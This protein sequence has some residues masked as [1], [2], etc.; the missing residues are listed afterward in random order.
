MQAWPLVV[1]CVILQIHRVWSLPGR[2]GTV[3][4]GEVQGVGQGNI[5]Q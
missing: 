3:D 5:L 4:G 2:D 1:G